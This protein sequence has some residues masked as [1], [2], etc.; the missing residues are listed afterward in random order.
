MAKVG[1]LGENGGVTRTSRAIVRIDAICA[2]AIDLARNAV[3]D[4]AG[5]SRIGGYVEASAVAERL[6][7]QVF[8]AHEPGYRGWHWSVTVMRAPRSRHVTVGEIALLPGSDALAPPPWVPWSQRVR[9]GDLGIGDLLPTAP[10]DDRL[11]PAYANT[12]DTEVSS[13]AWELGL[14]RTRVMSRYG[15]DETAERWY[16]SD[17]GPAAPVA[18]LAPARCG[19]CGFY[20]PLAGSL[21]IAFGACANVYAPDDGRVVTADH[22]CGAHSEALVDELPPAEPQP[23]PA[24]AS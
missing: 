9:P 10:D 1:G 2:E 5:E 24:D 19:T 18:R 13:V 6:V 4:F 8:E 11:V 12:E 7:N 14:G 23:L 3:I 21:G 17:A 15:R 22:G 16:E 20:A